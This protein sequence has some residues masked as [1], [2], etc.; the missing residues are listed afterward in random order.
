MKCIIDFETRS[1]IDIW[2]SGAWIYS[3][4]PSTKILC[5]AFAIDDKPKVYLN[6]K[7]K[8]I[9]LA[10]DP[11]VLFTA[12]NAFFER[13]IWKNIMVKRFN[14]PPIPLRRW[15]DTMA[16]AC[17][18]GLPQ[19]LVKAADALGIKQVKDM[20]GR[21][22]MKRMSRPLISKSGEK[23]Y[24][25]DPRHY[26]I[27]YDYCKQDVKVEREL[28]NR[29]P[30]LSPKEQ[31]IW[32][33]DQLINGRGV[34]VDIPV[35]RKII[36][37]LDERTKVLNKELT[38]ITGGK[39]TK[40]TQ[41]QSMLNYLADTGCY[42][43]NLQKGTVKDKIASGELT[44][45]HIRVLRL[46]QQLGR[47]STRKYEKLIHSTDDEGILRDCYVYHAATPGRWGGKLVQLQNLTYDK[48]GQIDPERTI[49]DIATLDTPTLKMNYGER[50]TD[51]IAKCIRGVFIPSEGQEFYIVDY[52]A[53][54]ARVLMWLADEQ[55]GLR[56]FKISDAGKDE[57][58][59]VKMA[60]RIYHNPHLTKKANK[61]E[62]A[63]GKQTILG[64]GYQMGGTKFCATCASNGI[65]IDEDKGQR[66]INLYRD[67]YKKVVNFWHDLERAMKSAYHH[68]GKIYSVRAIKYIYKKGN[69]YCALP[70]GRI[71]T[72]IEP[73]LGT[74][75]FGNENLSFMTEV[76]KQWVRRDTYGGL[77]AENCTQATA[78]D[79]MAYSFPRL[80]QANFPIVMHTHDEIVSQRPIGENRINQMIDLMCKVEPWIKGCPIKAEGE[81][82]RRYK[83]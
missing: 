17:A 41:V 30:D 49:N 67:T 6:D 5:Y 40:G 20:K 18:Y 13:S 8:L 48:T 16:K 23:Y 54:E 79:I 52:N 44:K 9:S 76:N 1:E 66:I 43:P 58:I 72:Y 39:V 81:I 37:L 35:V 34:K 38:R 19:A 61:Q 59:Y 29:L 69:I 83:K 73:K 82:C 51:V 68:P 3:T 26:K 10:K 50:L 25:D 47:T 77:L 11:N 36:R 53:I 46:R 55:I 24:D 15:R 2:E 28:D 32:F 45:T 56:E 42:M 12:H 27:L 65:E 22:M 4:H 80:E 64:S 14:F 75:K 71:L 60:R 70:S 74:N 31:E 63:L 21:Q 57:D 7:D 78:R 62:R 33:Y